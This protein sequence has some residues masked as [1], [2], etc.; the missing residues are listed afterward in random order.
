MVIVPKPNQP[1]ELRIAIDCKKGKQ[2]HQ[3]NAAQHIHN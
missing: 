1:K 3:E 2:G